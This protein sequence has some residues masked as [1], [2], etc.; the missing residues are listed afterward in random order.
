[1]ARRNQEDEVLPPPKLTMSKQDAGEIL[2][3]QIEEGQDI[4]GRTFSSRAELDEAYS[5]YKMWADYNFD[6]MG[7]M[8]DNPRYQ[9][10]HNAAFGVSFVGGGEPTFQEEV[11]ELRGDVSGE[12]NKLRSLQKRLKIIDVVPSVG[13]TP[14]TSIPQKAVDKNKVF[15]VHGHDGAAREATARLLEK[16]GLK[17]IILSE[18]ASGGRTIIEKLERY[19][20][21]GFA[22]V[23]LTPDD[24]GASAASPSTMQPR[25]RQNVIFELGFCIA[26]LGRDRVCTLY[27]GPMELPSDYTGVVYTPLDEGDAWRYT[28]TKELRHAG[29]SVSLDAVD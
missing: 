8:F 10:E 15:I 18:Q 1:M 27:R 23:L 7:R 2:Q 21:V 26:K 5:Q 17:P 12:I 29:Y 3:S 20:D 14:A 22:V 25:A 19:S 24:H 4:L 13:T 6:L 11:E 16:L 28:L 9:R